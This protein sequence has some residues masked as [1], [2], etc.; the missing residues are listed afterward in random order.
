[1]PRTDRKRERGRERERVSLT[2][3]THNSDALSRIAQPSQPTRNRH[4]WEITPTQELVKE[5]RITVKHVKPEDHL[6]D[7][8]T[9][10]LSKRRQGFLLKLISEFRA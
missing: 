10:H 2:G 9:K 7:I 4:F 3:H 5:G 8:V 1:M 6:A